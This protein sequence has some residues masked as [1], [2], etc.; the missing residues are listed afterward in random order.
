M[1]FGVV[2]WMCSVDDT[3]PGLMIMI[4]VLMKKDDPKWLI[5]WIFV[6]SL[7][8]HSTYHVGN[9]RFLPCRNY[10]FSLV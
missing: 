2:N 3:F 6:L 8:E 1:V 9:I 5:H 7:P 4:M 10:F